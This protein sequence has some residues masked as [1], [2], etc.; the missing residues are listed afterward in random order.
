MACISEIRLVLF[1]YLWAEISVY[2]TVILCYRFLHY[3]MKSVFRFSTS[4]Y[5]N[6][7][8]YTSPWPATPNYQSFEVAFD[9]HDFC[10]PPPLTFRHR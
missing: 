7:T 9:E 8:P 5:H 6:S 2:V 3:F 1:E 10:Q 4:L